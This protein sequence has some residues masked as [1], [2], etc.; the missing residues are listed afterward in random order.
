[1]EWNGWMD[2]WMG[3]GG[4]CVC[5]SKE[6]ASEGGARASIDDSTPRPFK[7]N[8]IQQTNQH[9][10]IP[11]TTTTTHI[12]GTAGA[13]STADQLLQLR[14]KR[15]LYGSDRRLRAYDPLDAQAQILLAKATRR[16]RGDSSGG[17]GGAVRGGDGSG[18]GGMTPRS[19]A[20]AAAGG[21]GAEE[22]YLDYA[23]LGSGGGG[24]G[25]ITLISTARVI[26]MNEEGDTRQIWRLA[27]IVFV[28]AVEA[29]G[30]PGVDRVS[31]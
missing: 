2:G 12:Q 20:A 15:A 3:K 1:M 19:V 23:E 8:H 22:F 6:R 14:P 26:V 7:C 25:G 5:E 31:R 16:A 17:G 18:G 28:E 9:K 10:T 30:R 4:G 13:A 11:I 29:G 27:D 24:E 21:G